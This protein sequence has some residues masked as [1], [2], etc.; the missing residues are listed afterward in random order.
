M[1]RLAGHAP[2]RGNDLSE[3]LSDVVLAQGYR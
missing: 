1:I 2:L 3:A